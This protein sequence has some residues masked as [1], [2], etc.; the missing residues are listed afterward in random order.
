MS[1][2]FSQL[3]IGVSVELKL[4]IGSESRLNSVYGLQYGLTRSGYCL[5]S[6]VSFG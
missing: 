4:T 1:L 5:G 2:D 3:F 6:F